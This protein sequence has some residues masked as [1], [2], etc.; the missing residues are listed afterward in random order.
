MIRNSSSRIVFE[1]VL[2]VLISIVLS[3]IAISTAYFF[4][5]S[6]GMHMFS[7]KIMGLD[8][9]NITLVNGRYVGNANSNSMIILGVICSMLTIFILEGLTRRSK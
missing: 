2:G 5:I 8:L 3:F 1:I 4:V 6:R 9:Y 7:L